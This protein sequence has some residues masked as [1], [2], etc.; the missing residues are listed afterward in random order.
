MAYNIIN[1]IIH[2]TANLITNLEHTVLKVLKANIK[3]LRSSS[4]S[5]NIHHIITKQILDQTY[6]QIKWHP[7]DVVIYVP[8]TGTACVCVSR[9]VV[10]FFASRIASCLTIS[11]LIILLKTIDILLRYL[12]RVEL[13]R[14]AKSHSNECWVIWVSVFTHSNIKYV[15]HATSLRQWNLLWSRKKKWLERLMTSPLT[16][17][18]GLKHTLLRPYC[19]S[20]MMS[21]TLWWCA[22]LKKWL[23][24]WRSFWEAFS[25]LLW[26]VGCQSR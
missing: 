4:G 10:C 16:N 22:T 8:A 18:V 20:T 9:N 21:S 24:V 12:W 7:D 26:V 19:H 5:Y 11:M 1:Y 17:H 13:D 25:W 2:H 3:I 6:R 15:S 23:L 14:G